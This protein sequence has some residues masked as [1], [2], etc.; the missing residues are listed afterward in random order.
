MV[1][2]DPDALG[3]AG[4][5]EQ[6]LENSRLDP[7]PID[8]VQAQQPGIQE[9]QDLSLQLSMSLPLHPLKA[10]MQIHQNNKRPNHLRC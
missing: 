5:S 3:S 7:V 9:N 2:Q 4:S 6:A 10:N 8:C 1:I